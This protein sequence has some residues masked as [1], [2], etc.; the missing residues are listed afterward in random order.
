M[1]A[2]SSDT[3][4]GRGRPRLPKDARHGGPVTGRSP[5]CA[6]FQ[7]FSCVASVFHVDA[8]TG[9]DAGREAGVGG[10]TRIAGPESIPPRSKQHHDLPHHHTR[11]RAARP[12]G[13][14]RPVRPVEHVDVR[15]EPPRSTFDHGDAEGRRHGLLHVHQLR[16]RPQR[17]H[18]A[19][20][21]LPAAARSGDGP[22]YYKLDPNGLYEIHIDNNGD[23]KE[24]ITFQFRFTNTLKGTALPI[25]GSNVAIPLTQSGQVA[26]VR[27]ANL[28]VNE[29]FTLNIVRGDRR[30]GTVAAVTNATTGSATFDKPSDN[31]GNKTIPNYAAYAAQYIYNDHHPPA[32]R[33]PGKVFV[34]QRKDPFAVNLGVIFDLV[35]IP[36]AQP[37]S[38][39]AEAAFVHRPDHE[40]RRHRRACARQER[41]HPRAG[42]ARPACLTAGTP[43]RPG[44]RRAGPPPAC[45]R[46]RCSA[47][48]AE[49]RLPDL[50]DR[51]RRVD[52]GL[53]PRQPA[54]QR[55]SIIGLPDK[56]KFNNSK[57]MRRRPVRHLRDEPDDSAS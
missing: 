56:D 30:T 36:G 6:A 16:S 43:V 44:D 40:G 8:Y 21:R 50:G 25:G 39:P 41:D 26:N 38:P 22:N 27:D 18:D 3:L 33:T 31:I 5:A 23:G 35:N 45:A 20:R 10:K 29:T 24:D 15:V 7:I 52:P 37:T 4:P 55:S 13:D 53:A 49:E 1:V 34:G 2:P 54:D 32:A 12:G 48:R 51:R 57:P 19:D 28:N 47:M 14:R 9:A 11:P 42:S 17:V 46:A